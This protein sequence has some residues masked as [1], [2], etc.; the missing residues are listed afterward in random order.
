MTVW[1]SEMDLMRG[2][3]SGYYQKQISKFT[4]YFV[5]V[6]DQAGYEIVCGPVSNDG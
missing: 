2:Q 4:D 6:P 1:N 3:E 5:R